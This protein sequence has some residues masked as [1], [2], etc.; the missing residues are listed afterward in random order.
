MKIEQVAAI[1]HAANREY[2][3][4]IG[5]DTQPSWA[6]APIWHQTSM[7][8]GVAFHMR[9]PDSKP[10]HSHECWLAQ[11]Q[12]DGWVWGPVK[13]PAAK[14]HPCMLPY[15]ELPAEQR[16]KDLLFLSIVRALQPMIDQERKD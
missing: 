10:E 6:N 4:H 12:A 3:H 13:D 2:C 1:C 5:D 16:T 14:Q 11:K 15:S 9:T 7:I 8:A